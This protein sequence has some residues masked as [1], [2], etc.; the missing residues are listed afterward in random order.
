MGHQ[1]NDSVLKG[2]AVEASVRMLE[3]SSGHI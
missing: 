3:A 2:L 1:K